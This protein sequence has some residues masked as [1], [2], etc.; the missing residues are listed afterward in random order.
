[1]GANAVV[2]VASVIIPGSGSNYT[3]VVFS[4][5][6]T[7]STLNDANYDSLIFPLPQNNISNVSNIDYVTTRQY[8]TGT[9]NSFAI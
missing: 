4:A 2:N 6:T 9:F 5:N 8:T 7:E 3:N 1:M